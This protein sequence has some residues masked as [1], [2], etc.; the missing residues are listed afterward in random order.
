MEITTQ[1]YL[2]LVNGTLVFTQDEPLILFDHLGGFD[3]NFKNRLLDVFLK[4]KC[5][6]QIYTQYQIDFLKLF[7]SKKV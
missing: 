6:N 4:N 1:H 3:A 5:K 2:D 7:V